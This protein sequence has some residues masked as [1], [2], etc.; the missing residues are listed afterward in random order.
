MSSATVSGNFNLTARGLSAIPA[1]SSITI[2]AGDEGVRVVGVLLGRP[3]RSSRGL[4]HALAA[5]TGSAAPVLAA[6][7]VLRGHIFIP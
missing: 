3:I 4:L 6:L 5:G 2:T 1:I 7:R